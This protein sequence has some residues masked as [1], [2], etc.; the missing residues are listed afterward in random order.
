MLPLFAVNFF[1]LWLPVFEL[2]IALGLIFTKWNREF[3]FLTLVL[4]G[5]FIIAL[6]Q[7][8]IRNLGITC[9]CFDIEGAQDKAGAWTALL[10]DFALL[11]P[12]IWLYLKGKNSYIWQFRSHKT[13]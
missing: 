8:L 10:R 4:F 3:S 2:V 9:G 7:A 1:S 6:T 12:L 5:M 13:A 11:P